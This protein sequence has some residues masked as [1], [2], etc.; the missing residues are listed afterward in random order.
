MKQMRDPEKRR[1]F[2]RAAA[3]C[4]VLGVVCALNVCGV[5]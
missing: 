1:W 4:V 5:I 2:R 3:V